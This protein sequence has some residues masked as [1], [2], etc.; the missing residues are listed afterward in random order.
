[1]SNEV[2]PGNGWTLGGGERLAGDP[3]GA[4]TGRE[5]KEEK[6]E[7]EEEERDGFL[8]R[9]PKRHPQTP[10]RPK[11]KTLVREKKRGKRKKKPSSHSFLP[12]PPNDVSS[13]STGE[14]K[15]REKG[16]R[17]WSV[18][19]ASCKKIFRLCGKPIETDAK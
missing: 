16:R 5:K 15:K 7:E 9:D 3:R 8:P 11:P 2:L 6:E 18:G 19:G 12:V 4:R 1:M 10:P 17:S 13:C 14:E